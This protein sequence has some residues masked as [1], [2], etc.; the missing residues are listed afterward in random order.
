MAKCDEGYR[1]EVCG[2]DVEEIVDSDLYL[3]Y[4]LG[5]VPLE[6]LH[7]QPERHICCNPALSQY[8]VDAAFV[9]AVC[10]GPFS[11]EELDPA[12]VRD[13]ETRVTR[14]WRRLQAIPKLGLSVPEYPLHVTPD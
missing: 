11:K 14:G 6:V 9:P 5:E 10:P 2:L 13:E 12:F 7:I 8:I 4:V 1:C 3:R